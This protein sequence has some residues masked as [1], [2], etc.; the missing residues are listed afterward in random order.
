MDKFKYFAVQ[1]N[2]P[3]EEN[4]EQIIEH[5]QIPIML[6]TE[7]GRSTHLDENMKE[8]EDFNDDQ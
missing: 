5:Y 8:V 2:F 4:Q 3:L 1:I 7:R 6:N